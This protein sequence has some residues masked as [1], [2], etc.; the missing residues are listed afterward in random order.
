MQILM[1]VVIQNRYGT[2]FKQFEEKIA[3]MCLIFILLIQIFYYIFMRCARKKIA[4]F[5]FLKSLLP[6]LDF[7]V[8]LRQ[9]AFSVKLMKKKR[10]LFCL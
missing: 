3:H 10:N 2:V 6:Y 7:F 8:Q 9:L 1:S 4:E 5:F